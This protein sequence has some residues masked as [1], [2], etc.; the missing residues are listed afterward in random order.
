MIRRSSSET[1]PQGRFKDR[2]GGLSCP[3]LQVIRLAFFTPSFLS[4]Y[5]GLM[6]SFQEAGRQNTGADVILAFGDHRLDLARRELRRGTELV[7]L[8]P[9]VFD[10]L[11]FLIRN[12]DRVVSKSDLLEAIWDGR[13]VSESAITTRINA[14]RRALGDDGAAQRLIRTFARKGFRFVVDV[15]EQREAPRPTRDI[16]E[17]TGAVDRPSIAVVPLQNLSGDPAQ[18][19]FADGMAEEIITALSRIRWLSVIAC[20]SSFAYRGQVVD[21][22]RVGRELGARYVLQGSVR[23]ADGRTRISAQL[24]EA[25]TGGHLWAD[26]FD[27]SCEDVFDL[28]DRVASGVAGVI[29]PALQAA[30]TVRS[31]SRGDLSAYAAH[32]RGWAMLFKSAK[33]IP[34][35]LAL[36]EEAIAHDPDY[37]PA[38]AFAAHCCMRLCMDGSS[39]HPGTDRRKG[40]EYARRALR[41]AGDDPGTLANA[42]MALAFFGEDIGTVTA[43]VDRA[44]MLNPSFARGWHISSMLR[45][46]SGQSALAIDHAETARQ[47]SPRGGIGSPFLN[48]GTAHLLSRRFDDALAALLFATQDLPSDF[49]SPYRLLIACY[50][51]MGRL[52]DAR[53]VLQHL[54]RMTPLINE[55]F[56]YYRNSE[57]RELLL[58]G[59][60]AAAG[61]TERRSVHQPGVAVGASMASRGS[62]AAIAFAKSNGHDLAAANQGQA[63]KPKL[64]SQ[65]AA[66]KRKNG[67]VGAVGGS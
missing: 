40:F 1:P 13:I 67:G 61:Q 25:T 14:L 23:K 47:L 32:L 30:E 38:L 12:R 43:L 3:K 27:G 53:E 36:L 65:A 48:I 10:L 5:G 49:P 41:L 59:L 24:I 56:S 18:D 64:K 2:I 7:D 4:A 60:R 62:S 51:Q 52:D 45:S 22:K 63:R 58:S 17:D 31:H 19:R 15:T 35:A 46:W 26:R 42:A 16:P 66:A 34:Q 33:Q 37:G 50:A 28:Q 44:L 20:N 11:A 54:R 57:H 55:G 21:V 6:I 9:K 29:E 39:Q 8:E